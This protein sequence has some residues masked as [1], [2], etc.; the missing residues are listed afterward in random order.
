MLSLL[1]LPFVAERPKQ[2]NPRFGEST[3]EWALGRLAQHCE[4]E[5]SQEGE[6]SLG[7]DLRLARSQFSSALAS[8]D[9]WRYPFSKAISHGK[10]LLSELWKPIA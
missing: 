4:A 9:H 6:V 3:P 8:L 7:D 2:A 10:D 5:P 1:S